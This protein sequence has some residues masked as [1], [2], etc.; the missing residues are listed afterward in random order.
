ARGLARFPGDKTLTAWT[1]PGVFAT[2]PPT[3]TNGSS[4]ANGAENTCLSVRFLILAE[5]ELRGSAVAAADPARAF[6]SGEEYARFRAAFLR[7]DFSTV[8]MLIAP[9]FGALPKDAESAFMLG[10]VLHWLSYEYDQR[11]ESAFP[12]S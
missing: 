3:V 8:G 9:K 1:K 6:T 2:D 5:R 11:L 7:D 10:Q 4:G 12:D